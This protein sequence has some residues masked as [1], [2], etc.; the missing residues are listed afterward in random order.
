M[1]FT[2]IYLFLFK[3]FFPSSVRSSQYRLRFSCRA[4]LHIAAKQEQKDAY[5]QKQ[6][7]GKKKSSAAV[8]SALT[9]CGRWASMIYVT[10]HVNHINH[11]GS[12]TVVD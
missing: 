11:A 10:N 8:L 5:R 3:H 1:F 7:A 2:S 12:E 9:G 6:V 4:Y